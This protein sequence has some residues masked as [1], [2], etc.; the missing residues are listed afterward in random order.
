M[1]I[2]YHVLSDNAI[3][4]ADMIPDPMDTFGRCKIQT[5]AIMFIAESDN[6]VSGNFGIL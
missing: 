3:G 4:Y 6:C 1:N 5:A 2:W